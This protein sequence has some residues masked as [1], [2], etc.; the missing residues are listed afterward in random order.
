M[1]Y[2]RAC[3][4]LL[5]LLT[6]RP[7]ARPSTALRQLARPARF[8]FFFASFRSSSASASASGW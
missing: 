6:H 3:A 8:Y 4:P 7:T 2:A 5:L 1:R